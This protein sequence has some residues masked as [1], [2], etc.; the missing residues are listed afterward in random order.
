MHEKTA[1]EIVKAI[2]PAIASCNGML[3]GKREMGDG[4]DVDSLGLDFCSFS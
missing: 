2:L 1:T 4:K 3:Q